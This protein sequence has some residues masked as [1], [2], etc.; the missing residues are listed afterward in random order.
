MQKK[1]W[2]KKSQSAGIK[3][4]TASAS[5]L[6]VNAGTKFIGNMDKTKPFDPK[7]AKLASGG[8]I[9]LGVASF[10]S[11]NEII[12]TAGVGAL[13]GGTSNLLALSSKADE[14][15]EPT[16][17]QKRLSMIAPVSGLGEVDD[18]TVIMPTIS[19]FDD[20]EFD[21]YED[22]EDE[23]VGGLLSRKR[24]LR[25]AR[26]KRER[27]GRLKNGISRKHFSCR[28]LNGL[29]EDFAGFE[30]EQGEGELEFA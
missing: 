27:Q 19:E 5:A 6:V 20:D 12:Q 28:Q 10:L 18:A 24:K 23:Q 11:D 25:I 1:D 2:A 7:K 16:E 17:T 9:L 21:D 22:Y 26:K 3:L 4:V 29:E 8:A 15:T 13:V 14:G 30:D